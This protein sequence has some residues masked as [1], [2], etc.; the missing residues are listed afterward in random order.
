MPVT[1]THTDEIRQA[2]GSVTTTRRI[3][4]VTVQATLVDLH[5]RLRNGLAANRSFLALASP[6][7]AQRNQQVERLT[8]QNNQMIR[9]LIALSGTRSSGEPA[10]DL[11][12]DETVD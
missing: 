12:A 10:D 6:T 4:D 8:R 11:L 7:A 3:E 9:I 1:V 2:D 5:T